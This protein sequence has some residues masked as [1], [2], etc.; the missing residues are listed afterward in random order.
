MNLESRGD[1]THVI[2]FGQSMYCELGNRVDL[3]G[4]LNE[5][6]D[7]AMVENSHLRNA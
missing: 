3:M 4:R 1:V 7:N 6:Q 2:N 5:N